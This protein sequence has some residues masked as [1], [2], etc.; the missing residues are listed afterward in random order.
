MPVVAGIAAPHLGLAATRR[1][2]I[3]LG[4]LCAAGAAL[5]AA[6]AGLALSWAYLGVAL[7]GTFSFA[8]IV[9]VLLVRPEGLFGRSRRDRG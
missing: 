6:T 1:D 9:V 7:R 2:A 8:V 4:A 3:T 5:V